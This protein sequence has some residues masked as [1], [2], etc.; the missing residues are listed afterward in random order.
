M[1][2]NNIEQAARHVRSES[3]VAIYFR[4]KCVALLANIC[5]RLRI[6]PNKTT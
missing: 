3:V 5:H 6:G 1:V 2:Y 4:E